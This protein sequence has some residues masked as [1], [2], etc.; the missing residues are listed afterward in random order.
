MISQNPIQTEYYFN[1]LRPTFYTDEDRDFWRKFHNLIRNSSIEISINGAFKFVDDLLV[2]NSGYGGGGFAYMFWF[3]NLADRDA[4]IV[5]FKELFPGVFDPRIITSWHIPSI[6]TMN[7]EQ[8]ATY[9]KL[10]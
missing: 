7:E 8:K 3:H 6:S 5:E 1:T 9:G 4:F 2:A 10:L